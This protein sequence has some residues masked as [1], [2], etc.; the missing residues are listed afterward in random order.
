MIPIRDALE[1]G[2]WLKAEFLPIYSWE[3][4]VNDGEV[5]LFRIRV[6]E[7]SKVD[8]AAVDECERLSCGL[9]ANI[10]KLGLDVVNLCKKEFQPEILIDGRLFVV[11]E[12]GFQFQMVGDN[13]LRGVSQYSKQSGMSAFAFFPP[14]LPPK[15]KRSGAFPYELPDEFD[16]LFLSIRDGT[17]CEA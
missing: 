6:T 12:D 4:G 10:W 15:I 1:T 16:Q 5:I 13:H 7:F 17:L 3:H 9:D 2:A 8:L 14:A 11:D